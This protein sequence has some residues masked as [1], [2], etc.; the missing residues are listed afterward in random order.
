[1]ARR[2]SSR[3]A[4]HNP[5]GGGDERDTCEGVGVV[6]IMDDYGIEVEAVHLRDSTMNAVTVAN[7]DTPFT[8]N[9]ANNI[10]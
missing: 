6:N 2:L 8:H 7:Q 1:M 5:K 10:A 4:V 3:E 9:S